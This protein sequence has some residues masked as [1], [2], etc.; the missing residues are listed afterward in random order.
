MAPIPIIVCGRRAEIAKFVR[1]SL[2]PEYDVVHVITSPE[3]GS[4]DIPILLRGEKL[5]ESDNP[6]SRN[7]GSTPLAVATGGGY[8]DE[9]F[10]QMRDACLKDDKAKVV[11]W[12][13]PDLSQI[14][15]MPDL[16]DAEAYG[17]KTADRLRIVL[18]DLDLKGES[19]VE[20]KKGAVIF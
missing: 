16:S 8:D 14:S 12:L 19:K 13:R 3:E 20:W 18:N 2:A 17:R 10:N 11:P 1:E 6:G 15:S 9:A 4:S 5:P 7:Y